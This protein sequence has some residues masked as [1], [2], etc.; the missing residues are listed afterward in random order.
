MTG[1]FHWDLVADLRDMWSAAFMVNAF[2]AGLIVA[3]LA[4]TTGWFMVL[5][6]QTFAGHTLAVAGFPGAA[7]AV[8]LGAGLTYGYYT[9][10]LA[11]ALAIAALPRRGDG[12]YAEQ[13]AAIATVQAFA[14]AAG[15]LFVSLYKG[16]LGGTNAL[17]F[18]SVLG[19][20]TNQVTTLTLVAAVVLAVLALL[21]RPLLFAS[22]DPEVAAAHGVP[23]RTLDTAFLLLLGLTVAEVS[24]ITGSLLVFALLVLP[25]A[26]ARQFTARPVA[27]LALSVALAAVTVFAALFVA[28]YSP[29]PVGFWLTTLAF[30]L[31]VTASAT[32]AARTRLGQRT[33]R[34]ASA[35][36]PAGA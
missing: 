22:V 1:T 34:P 6:R 33:A 23:T 32:T 18:G 9:F 26:T 21:G 8:W 16:F 30:G 35:I 11:A 10:C 27:G 25:A 5:R 13:S 12:G 36:T 24:Q 17:L 4:A 31:Y 15:M 7:G 2:R 19:I 3:V 29:Y 28:Y 20:T 14:L